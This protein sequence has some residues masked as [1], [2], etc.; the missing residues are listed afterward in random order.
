MSFYW[1]C[2]LLRIDYSAGLN[3]IIIFGASNHDFIKYA[4]K[5]YQEVE[6]NFVAALRNS[7]YFSKNTNGVHHIKPK[8][9]SLL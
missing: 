7:K 2:S 3:G 6:N 5:E 9:A 4:V 1:T 8:N